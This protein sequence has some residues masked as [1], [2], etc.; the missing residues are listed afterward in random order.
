[1]LPASEHL[2][3]SV[4]KRLAQPAV[5]PV[6]QRLREI[7]QE[8]VAEKR[9]MDHRAQQVI[10]EMQAIATAKQLAFL[11]YDDVSDE[12]GVITRMTSHPRTTQGVAIPEHRGGS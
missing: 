7:S 8:V 12:W 2:W 11:V 5:D 3:A 6:I 1:M 10:H 9:A 4:T